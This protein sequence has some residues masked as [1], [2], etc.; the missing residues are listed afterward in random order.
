[1]VDDVGHLL[2][3]GVRGPRWRLRVPGHTAAVHFAGGQAPGG[4][5]NGKVGAHLLVADDLE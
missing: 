2:F 3:G 5:A 1:L 4:F